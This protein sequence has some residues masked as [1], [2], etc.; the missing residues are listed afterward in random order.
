MV[1]ILKANGYTTNQIKISC[2]PEDAVVT[3]KGEDLLDSPCT[4]GIIQGD[5]QP[6][7]IEKNKIRPTDTF[8]LLGNAKKDKCRV[9]ID[10]LIPETLCPYG[11]NKCS[12]NGIYQPAITNFKFLVNFHYLRINWISS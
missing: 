5:D 1:W 8:N 12:F 11:Q 4:N 7:T 3:I 9:E 2:L 6:F 10:N